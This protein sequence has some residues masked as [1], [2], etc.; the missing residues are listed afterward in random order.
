M[1]LIAQRC[2]ASIEAGMHAPGWHVLNA[3]KSTTNCPNLPLPTPGHF[4]RGKP[5][6]VNSSLYYSR[7]G[8]GV[9]DVVF[10]CQIR[11]VEKRLAG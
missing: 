5:T 11:R 6:T 3:K 2:D 7:E 10:H 8:L 1:Q 9:A 4:S